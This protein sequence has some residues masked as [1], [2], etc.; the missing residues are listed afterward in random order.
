[1]LRR[2]LASQ[3]FNGLIIEMT[4]HESPEIILAFPEEHKSALNLLEEM[5]KQQEAEDESE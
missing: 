4:K 1:M 3:W 2:T 5:D